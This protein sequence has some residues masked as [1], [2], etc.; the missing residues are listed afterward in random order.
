M[1]GINRR[2]KNPVH[3]ESSMKGSNLKNVKA[4]IRK[5]Q[6][7]PFD[8]R[9]GTITAPKQIFGRPLRPVSNDTRY[10]TSLERRLGDEQPIRKRMPVFAKYVGKQRPLGAPSDSGSVGISKDLTKLSGEETQV[11]ELSVDD[12]LAT[13]NLAGLP[14]GYRPMQEGWEDNRSS[15]DSIVNS[16][17]DYTA[18]DVYRTPNADGVMGSDVQMGCDASRSPQGCHESGAGT[19][20]LEVSRDY[21]FLLA[22]LRF[23]LRSLHLYKAHHVGTLQDSLHQLSA[24]GKEKFKNGPTQARPDVEHPHHVTA[25]KSSSPSAAS[26]WQEQGTLTSIDDN[27][28]IES[29]GSAYDRMSDAREDEL[30]VDFTDT[31]ADDTCMDTMSGDD[32]DS[33]D[34]IRLEYSHEKEVTSGNLASQPS[35]HAE[36][37]PPK[38]VAHRS[39][40]ANTYGTSRHFPV[41]SIDGSAD[42]LD[43][44]E[45]NRHPYPRASAAVD[46]AMGTIITGLSD[47]RSM[48]ASAR[49]LLSPPTYADVSNSQPYL[50]GRLQNSL[51]Q[52]QRSGWNTQ[53]NKNRYNQDNDQAA[54]NTQQS[55]RTYR[56]VQEDQY[57]YDA[58]RR[59]RPSRNA[60]QEAQNRNPQSYLWYDRNPL[61]AR[62]E[63][64]L[65]CQQEAIHFMSD[66]ERTGKRLNFGVSRF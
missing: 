43:A 8:S 59:G 26:G 5:L 61:T 18:K 56:A 32:P 44:R 37:P 3:D 24:V 48:S 20:E 46:S 62:N 51:S 6:I 39:S 31:D 15:H 33:T 45:P 16:D 47:Y 63:G 34:A 29:F 50:N 57:A 21:S 30:G 12:I 25:I 10:D 11:G 65:E 1:A 2:R 40:H 19:F 52:Y 13:S 22:V 60:S 42:S 35:A 64:V 28:D 41:Q 55:T 54:S 36:R 7:R 27:V 4:S 49:P 17:D 53:M 14:V 23:R 66:T 38:S 9:M 58:L